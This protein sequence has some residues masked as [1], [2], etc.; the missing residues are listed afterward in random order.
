MGRTTETVTGID[1]TSTGSTTAG[2]A[3]AA[4]PGSTLELVN[5]TAE[6]TTNADADWN[7]EVGGDDAF[8]TEQSVAASGTPEQFV[9]DQNQYDSDD[10]STIAVDV[11]SAGTGG[12]L[13]FTLV[14][15]DGRGE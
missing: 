13:S 3:A 11:S 15:E 6:Q 1:A 4:F 9:P 2:F 14:F 10:T 5:V 7:I 12:E 8:S